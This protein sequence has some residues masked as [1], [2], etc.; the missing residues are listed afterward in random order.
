ML[1]Y[2]AMLHHSNAMNMDKT[3]FRIQDADICKQGG[4]FRQHPIL[5]LGPTSRVSVLT[6]A[7][8]I[9]Y[10]GSV[11]I[12]YKR[13]VHQK[14]VSK[15]NASEHH[16]FYSLLTIVIHTVHA[17]SGFLMFTGA[18]L[19]KG[20]K[21]YLTCDYSKVIAIRFQVLIKII[22]IFNFISPSNLLQC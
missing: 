22:Y 20:I 14:S 8:S 3:C 2:D 12:L 15:A 16:L 21:V 6:S 11:P 4:Y 19:R 10:C 18:R 1:K 5:L 13:T 17:W 9:W 7:I